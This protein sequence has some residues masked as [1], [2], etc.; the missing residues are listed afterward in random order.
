[1]KLERSKDWWMTR[2]RREGA[3]AIGAGLLAFD[4]APEQRLLNAPA[5]GAAVRASA[6][7]AAAAEGVCVPTMIQRCRKRYLGW[8][9]A[10]DTA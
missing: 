1:M 3:A 2:A 6:S 9:Y 4:P 5:A 7:L 8:R 10:D